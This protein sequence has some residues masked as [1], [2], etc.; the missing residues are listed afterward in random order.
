[1]KIRPFYRI[2]PNDWILTSNPDIAVAR[3]KALENT[4]LGEGNIEEYVRQWVLKELLETYGYPKEWLG[5]RIVVEETVQM[6]TMEKQAD[7]SIKNERHKTFLYI[8]TK[9]MDITTLEFDKA[10]KQLMGYLSSTHTATVGMI[11]NG[12]V[13]KCLV[14]KI[15]PN[16]F[17][18]IPDIPSYNQKG[19]RHKS[20]LVRELT[21]EMVK[22]GRKTGLT[23]ITENTK[24]FFLDATQQ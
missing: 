11:T 21:P 10:E 16:D 4:H 18:Y 5:E 6:A 1:M 19:L 22:V 2:H 17:D 13:I 7:V 9:N 8:E 20:K 12:K 14:K 23:P 3:K 24:I 15:D